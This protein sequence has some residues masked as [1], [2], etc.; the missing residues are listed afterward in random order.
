EDGRIP[1]NGPLTVVNFETNVGLVPVEIHSRENEEDLSEGKF[2]KV[3][4]GEGNEVIIRKIMMQTTISSFR[5]STISLQELSGI[6]KV[7]PIEI[8][9]TGLPVEIMSTGLDQLIIPVRSKETILDLN[10]DLIKLSLLNRKYGVDTNHIFSLD[11]WAEDCISYARHFAPA[12]GMWEDP[13]TGTA[14]AGLGTY[15]YRHGI[16]TNR[17]MVMEQGKEKGAM[18]RILVELKDNESENGLVQIGGLAVTSIT[19]KIEMS[20]GAITIG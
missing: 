20:E 8:S 11:T 17:S 15:L 14:S 3:K 6:L 2:I 12:V 18:A 1:V 4:T 9:G 13:A 16:A 10:P 19:R 7:D 5:E